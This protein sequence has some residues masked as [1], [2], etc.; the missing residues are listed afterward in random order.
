MCVC[1][2][3][4]VWVCVSVCVCEWVCVCVWVCVWMSLCVCVWVC[5][6]VCVCEWVCARVC[7]CEWVC[8][9][10]CERERESVCVCVCVWR[11]SCMQLFSKMYLLA[12]TSYNLLVS[13][14]PPCSY[15]ITL[16][17]SQSLLNK[18]PHFLSAPILI[19]NN[20]RNFGFC[21]HKPPPLCNPTEHNSSTSRI[22]VSEATILSLTQV[23][24]FS[25][26]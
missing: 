15:A 8:V 11:Y 17:P 23:K 10:M 2:S 16:D 14:S 6:C 3:E 21:L 1:V 24:L 7:V 12:A 5:A 20:S 4:C 25:I 26:T 19:L 13:T 18:H 9:C 22:C